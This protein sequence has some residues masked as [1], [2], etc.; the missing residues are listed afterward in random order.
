MDWTRIMPIK[1]LLILG[2]LMLALIGCFYGPRSE[3]G[4]MGIN[5]TSYG[6]EIYENTSCINRGDILHLH[7][8]LTNYGPG[9]YVFESKN[10]PVFDMGVILDD[11]RVNWSDGKALT[12]DLTQL[13][14][15]PDESRTIEMDWVV[16]GTAR[17]GS[18]WVNVIY[19]DLLDFHQGA[20]VPFFV[21]PCPGPIGP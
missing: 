5:D 10:K 4:G 7:A 14:L 2:I 6:V 8:R 3:S 20:S 1:T 13:E 21:A 19:D 12:P 18:A 15:K 17:S 16:T 11:V 9:T